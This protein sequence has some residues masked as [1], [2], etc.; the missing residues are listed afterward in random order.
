[1]TDC[2]FAASAA[3]TL[4]A[5]I[6]A[7]AAPLRSGMGGSDLIVLSRTAVAGSARA[8]FEAADASLTPISG[9]R[10]AVVA[11]ISLSARGAPVFD[12]PASLVSIVAPIAAELKRLGAVV[13]AEPHELI[14]AEAPKTFI[15]LSNAG[16]ASGRE[17]LSVADI[18]SEM[19]GAIVGVYCAP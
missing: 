13:L 9:T 11:A 1:M 19:R 5:A 12:R 17:P 6:G 3:R 7:G 14:G 10:Q 15:P 16:P 2:R 4:V 18:A 8:V